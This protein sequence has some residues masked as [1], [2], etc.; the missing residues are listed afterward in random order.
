MRRPRPCSVKLASKEW[1]RLLNRFDLYKLQSARRYKLYSSEQSEGVYCEFARKA[2]AAL[3]GALCSGYGW[4]S[5]Q[6]VRAPRLGLAVVVRRLLCAARGG[7]ITINRCDH[8]RNHE[9]VCTLSESWHLRTLLAPACRSAAGSLRP[10]GH[11]G[12]A[13]QHCNQYSRRTSTAGVQ[14]RLLKRQPPAQAA[15]FQAS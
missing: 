1:R 2:R 8:I 5:R 3:E 7:N 12:H 9:G 14:L 4:I 10:L 15:P 11:C 6:R 13:L